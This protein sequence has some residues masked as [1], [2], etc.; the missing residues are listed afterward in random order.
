MKNHPQITEDMASWTDMDM[1]S[2][3]LMECVMEE[4]ISGY[5]A[6]EFQYGGTMVLKDRCPLT[7]E[8]WEQT[9]LLVDTTPSRLSWLEDE[10]RGRDFHRRLQTLLESPVF[11]RNGEISK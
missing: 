6:M 2:Q 9:A 3:S 10:C 7:G 11:F 5:E 4:I 8:D 1:Y